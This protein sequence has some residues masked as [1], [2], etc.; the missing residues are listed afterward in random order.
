MS[1]YKLSS[2]NMTHSTGSFLNSAPVELTSVKGYQ[3]FIAKQR[4]L[5]RSVSTQLSEDRSMWYVLHD[6][7]VVA[8]VTGDAKDYLLQLSGET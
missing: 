3:D 7:E 8:T 6:S 5:K 2:M 4:K 1:M